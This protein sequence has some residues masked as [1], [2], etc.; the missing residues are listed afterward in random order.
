MY[1]RKAFKFR[2]NVSKEK[3]AE[4]FNFAGCCRFVWNKAIR[5]NRA[6]LD[7]KQKIMRYQELDFWS[8]LWKS[9]E[10][11]GFL[12]C[13]H[14]QILQQKLKD[15][16]RAYSDGFDKNQ[17]LKIMPRLKKKGQGDS[18]RY[19][20]GFK[21]NGNNV[22]L[23]KLGWFSFRQSREIVG[24]AKNITVSYHGG[25]WFVSIQ[26]EQEVMI[27]THPSTKIVGIDVGIARFA[28]LSNGHY[29]ASKITS[30]GWKENYA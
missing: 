22:F 9:S 12:K 6:R 23:P 21:L 3:Q 19:L 7:G 25:H 16:D 8:K 15:L 2:L 14:S 27:P 26:T 30:G 29:F 13:C 5:I 1:I 18:F 11:Y 17:P 20:Q 28:T 4:F 10:E 24:T